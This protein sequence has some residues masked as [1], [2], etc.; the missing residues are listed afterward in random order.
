MVMGVRMVMGIGMVKTMVMMRIGVTM[1]TKMTMRMTMMMAIPSCQSS[2]GS[3]KVAAAA[4]VAAVAAEVVAIVVMV[5]AVI[6]TVMGVPEQPESELNFQECPQSLKAHRTPTR[7][8]WPSS[9]W[10]GLRKHTGEGLSIGSWIWSW[11]LVAGNGKMFDRLG[12]GLG[13]VE[14]VS[15]P[16]SRKQ[17]P[18][19]AAQAQ[20]GAR[21]PG[22]IDYLED[23]RS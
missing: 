21:Q 10:K 17:M 1:R 22:Y 11:G 15:P 12:F 23:Q 14:S 13:L 19:R 20:L 16:A 2:S 6:F 7:R 8:R 4:A 9:W 5:P 18:R 3:R